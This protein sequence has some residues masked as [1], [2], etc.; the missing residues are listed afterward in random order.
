M[1][2]VPFPRVV[3]QFHDKGKSLAMSIELSVRLE[4][5][6]LEK[7]LTSLERDFPNY[8]QEARASILEEGL[9]FVR[10]GSPYHYAA[11]G[12]RVVL[13]AGESVCIP[14]SCSVP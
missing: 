12:A 1:R 4:N 6:D 14:V 13:R 9:K 10:L 11:G 5:P 3:E 8:S 7:L 2:Y